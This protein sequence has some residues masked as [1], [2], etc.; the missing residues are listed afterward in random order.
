MIVVLTMVALA[1]CMEKQTD[2]TY[3]VPASSTSKARDNAAKAGDQVKRTADEIGKSDAAQK[4]KAGT[5]ELG[6]A[7]EKGL[8]K[9][10]QAAGA[11]L[12]QAGAK[13]E[14]D[15]KKPH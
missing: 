9:A 4:I 14:Q 3:R 7:A 1:S 15:A 5:R 8:G 13:A 11:K 2:G 10:A 12:Q 6:R